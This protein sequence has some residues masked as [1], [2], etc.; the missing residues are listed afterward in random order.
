MNQEL[1]LIVTD[2]SRGGAGVARDSQGRVVFIPFTAPGDRV[3][4]QI[5]EEDRRYAQGKLLEVLEASPHR[6]SPRCPA[7]TQC[8]GCQW[9]HLP[10]SLQWSTKISGVAQALKRVQVTLPDQVEYLPA[11]QIWEYRNRIQLR[12]RTQEGKVELGF[13]RPGT[14]ELVP[15]NRCDIAR[16][17]INENWEMTREQGQKLS[18]PFKVEVEV[19]EN[20]RVRE[21]WNARHA[22]AGFRQVH[23]EQ[24]ER[25]R[26]WILQALGPSDILY[27]LFGGKGNLSLPFADQVKEIHCVDFSSPK[28]TPPGTPSSMHFH[29]SDVLTW[30][31]SYAKQ[32][33]SIS[34]DQTVKAIL[35]P[36]REG[37]GGDFKDIA[38]SLESLGVKE[39]VAV[40]CDPDSWARDL[41]RWLKRGWILKRI[42]LIDLFPQTSH[43]ESIAVL[44]L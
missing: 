21:T 23:D 6:I 39:L 13:F 11:N 12:G 28:K 27:D 20:G 19:L 36:P 38:V 42:M 43:V 18:R 34:E 1:E 32:Q 3:K 44:A 2:L 30:A 8:G 26:N 4:V 15:V 24:N 33:R 5:L 40:G 31:I 41:S 14:Q 22:S 10:Y 37:L 29:S 35:D 25:L 7:F 17:E 16:K 9:Q